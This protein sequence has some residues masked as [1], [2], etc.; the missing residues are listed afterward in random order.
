MP[1][2]LKIKPQ[3]PERPNP[4]TGIVKDREE[5]K[6]ETKEIYNLILGKNTEKAGY[7]EIFPQLQQFV[8]NI[9]KYRGFNWPAEDILIKKVHGWSF[10]DEVFKRPQT[11][12]IIFETGKFGSER[13][14]LLIENVEETNLNYAV[15]IESSRLVTLSKKERDLLI[16]YGLA[17]MDKLDKMGHDFSSRKELISH[18]LTNNAAKTLMNIWNIDDYNIL[19]LVIAPA[20]EQIDMRTYTAEHK[21]VLEMGEDGLKNEIKDW[22]SEKEGYGGDPK[23]IKNIR[24]LNKL[25]EKNERFIE[26]LRAGTLQKKTFINIGVLY[27]TD[28]GIHYVKFDSEPQDKLPD[29]TEHIIRMTSVDECSITNLL[30]EKNKYQRVL[31]VGKK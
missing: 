18:E 9:A 15:N 21:K 23:Y 11:P 27:Q 30:K 29:T 10:A 3:Q 24:Q 12:E 8:G 26:E 31:T 17:C 25:I 20:T 16:E 28:S 22:K 19:D 6:R 5:I 7:E 13:N 14:T 4:K 2:I 1:E